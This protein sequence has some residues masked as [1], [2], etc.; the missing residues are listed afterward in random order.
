VV[1]WPLTGELAAQALI[2]EQL[3]AGHIEIFHSPWNMP[4]FVINKK[5][6]K[7]RLPQDLRAINKVMQPMG[8]LKPGLP[9]PTAIPL[10]NY[11]YIIDLKDCFFSIAL[12]EEDREKFAFSVHMPKHQS[13]CKRC[14]WKVLPQGVKNSSTMCQD[15][16]A[17]ALKHL[18]QNINQAYIKYRDGILLSHPDLDILKTYCLMYNW[19]SEALL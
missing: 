17:A 5:S 11:L 12:H 7:W 18:R 10:Q 4:I 8:S 6:G 15:F 14:H 9:S 16:V 13:P 3:Q 2:L 1:L 19:Q